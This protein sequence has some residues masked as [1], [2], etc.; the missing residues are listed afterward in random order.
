[1]V[2]CATV[3]QV[4]GV[5]V[6]KPNTSYGMPGLRVGDLPKA[7]MA[8]AFFNFVVGVVLGGVMA[9]SPTQWGM[10][11]PIHAELNPFGWLTLLIYGMTYAVLG[12]FAG[13]RLPKPLVGWIQL[14][15]AE[16][17]VVLIIVG[18]MANS[19]AISIIGFACQTIAPLVFLANVMMAVMTAHKGKRTN[20]SRS[21]EKE[22]PFVGEKVSIGIA[23]DLLDTRF[24]TKPDG[25]RKTDRI[26]ERGTSF[27]L[28]M[29]IVGAIWEFILRLL[30]QVPEPAAL[31]PT[32]VLVYYGWIVGTVLSVSLHLVPRYVKS[33]VITSRQAATGQWLWLIGT[34]VTAAGSLISPILQRVGIAVLGISMIVYAVSYLWVMRRAMRGVVLA[35]AVSWWASWL[36]ALALGISLLFGL[37]PTSLI[38]LHLLFLG[39]ITTLVY[40]IGYTF[41]PALFNRT[42]PSHAVSVLQVSLSLIG[43]LLMVLAFSDLQS[44]NAQ[45][46]LPFL[47]VGG[48]LA[49]I[50]ALYFL[51]QWLFGRKEANHDF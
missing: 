28:M 39:F 16:L 51:L 20:A 27:A 40:G 8:M 31:T 34:V 43:A 6:G 1:M 37:D 4:L 2:L 23:K 41:F 32:T 5:A 24:F 11:A 12:L 45:S 29:F 7:F 50:G 26:A 25:I 15:L 13:L 35:S 36:F 49:A 19:N 18:I 44:G 10:L 30:G 42:V 48:T 3:R 38:A 33:A 21:V 9:V 14:A 47:A 22:S 46:A 17:G